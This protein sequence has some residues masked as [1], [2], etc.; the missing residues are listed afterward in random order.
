MLGSILGFLALYL[1][2]FVAAVLLGHRLSRR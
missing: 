1:C 2:L